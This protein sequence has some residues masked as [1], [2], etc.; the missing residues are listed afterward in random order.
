MKSGICDQQQ[1]RHGALHV[2]HTAGSDSHL[3][4]CGKAARQRVDL[5]ILVQLLQLRVQP[6]RVALSVLGLQ[7]L[8]CR[9]NGLHLGGRLDLHL[10]Q[11]ESERLNT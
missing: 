10:G 8:G 7:G 6:R 1:A 4:E 3:G 5:V 2:E 9:G 11:W